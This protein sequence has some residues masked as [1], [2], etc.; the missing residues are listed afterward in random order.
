MIVFLTATITFLAMVILFYV[1]ADN[2]Y[3]HLETI[4]ASFLSFVERTV[5]ILYIMVG[6][7]KTFSKEKEL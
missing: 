7:I 6:H 1:N 3:D 5:P 4:S 2:N